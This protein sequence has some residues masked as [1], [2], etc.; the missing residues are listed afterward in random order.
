[1][2]IEIHAQNIIIRN[3]K[4]IPTKIG[5]VDNHFVNYKILFIKI[6]KQSAI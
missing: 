4:F 6:R 1:M 3:I 5:A 2:K